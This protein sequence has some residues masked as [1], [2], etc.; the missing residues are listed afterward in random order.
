MGWRLSKVFKF[1][2]INTTIGKSGVGWSVGIPGLRYG[3][4]TLGR[5][6][7]SLGFGPLRFF[8]HLRN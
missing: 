7:I 2:P 6:Y 1:G 8:K 3:R 5:P 4:D